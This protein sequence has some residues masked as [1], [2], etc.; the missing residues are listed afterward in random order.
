ML[1]KERVEIIEELKRLKNRQNERKINVKKLQNELSLLNSD[2]N[3]NDD[4]IMKNSLKLNE[5][6]N[7]KNL[8]N[9]I[10]IALIN[11]EI[12]ERLVENEGYYESQNDKLLILGGFK[13][14]KD[15]LNA[16]LK[17]LINGQ[18]KQIYCWICGC[19][20]IDRSHIEKELEDFNKLIKNLQDKLDSIRKKIR[21]NKEKILKNQ[22]LKKRKNSVSDIQK[23]IKPIFEYTMKLQIGKN[24][25]AEKI[26]WIKV[27]IPAIEAKIEQHV[28]E[29]QQKELE[30]K[31]LEDQIKNRIY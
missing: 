21:I 30:L 22:E 19:N 14:D 16:V 31:I 15:R 23:Q 3:K 20:N 18:E 2:I 17:E 4:E 24:V 9:K 8:V 5:L 12:E 1:K 27:K 10:N 11:K 7:K 29:I 25:Q 13:N 28:K 26:N 6:Y